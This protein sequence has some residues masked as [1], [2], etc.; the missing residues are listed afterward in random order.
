MLTEANSKLKAFC[1]K[2]QSQ[3]S[4]ITELKRSRDEMNEQFSQDKNELSSQLV[5]LRAELEE[6]KKETTTPSEDISSEQHAL[7][8]ERMEGLLSEKTARIST[9]EKEQCQ[10]NDECDGLKN[11]NVALTQQLSDS[12]TR[13]EE[14]ESRYQ[15]L[16]NDNQQ[17]K[18]QLSETMSKLES[19][20]TDKESKLIV[21]LEE[22]LA[23]VRGQLEE[24]KSDMMS[25][26]ETHRE[27]TKKLKAFILKLKKQLKEKVDSSSSEVA[28]R[29]EGEGLRVAMETVTAEKDQLAV[30]LSE[31]QT[32][33]QVMEGQVQELISS[34][35]SRDTRIEELVSIRDE[36]CVRVTT[37][38]EG[39]EVAA[40]E[41]ASTQADLAT[42]HSHSNT[43]Q[44]TIEKL[45]SSVASVRDELER[46][47]LSHSETRDKLSTAQ[48]GAQSSTLMNLELQDYQRSIRSLEEEV[49][50]KRAELES[51]QKEIHTHLDKIEQLKKELECTGA[52]RGAEVETV[53]KLKALLVR[54]KKE[55]VEGRRKEVELGEQ[56][57]QLT[58]QLESGRGQSE[59][60]KVELSELSARLHSEQLASQSSMEALQQ[61]V[62]GLE[63]KTAGLQSQLSSSQASLMLVQGEYDSYKVRVHSVLKQRSTAAEQVDINPEIKKSYEDEITNLK[64]SL[65]NTKSQLSVVL[66]DH[67]ELLSEHDTL[68]GR[69]DSLLQEAQTTRERLTLRVREVESAYNR[70]SVE[71][72]GLV[73]Q[74]RHEIEELTTAFTNQI[75]GL[76][77][78][79]KKVVL[80]LR[81]ELHSTHSQL[82][83]L[84]EEGD[85]K[86]FIRAS[87]QEARGVVKK[88]LSLEVKPGALPSESRTSGVG[89]DRS[90]LESSYPSTPL[91]REDSSASLERLL[92]DT[93]G[94]SLTERLSDTELAL[95]KRLQSSGVKIDH[96]TE[97]LRES[98]ASSV[99]LSEQAKL[100][101]EEIRRLERNQERE[102]VANMEYLKN[103]VLEFLH[104]QDM[105]EREGL[106][107][108][109]TKLLQLSPQEV[110]F[111]QDSIQGDVGDGLP[112]SAVGPPALGAAGSKLS[113]YIHRWTGY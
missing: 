49:A 104:T 53:S 91:S 39:R 55:L 8:V 20:Q 92:S 50:S 3:E 70:E 29:E 87:S 84:Q 27:E 30:R 1:E 11:R 83:R 41:L 36:L 113:S 12:N 69:H 89:M 7:Q 60:Y 31:A 32:N 59:E 58:A 105:K 4:A 97:L 80:G 45:Q 26:H 54:N 19:A 86:V 17:S 107:P 101:K 33:S 71:Q 18:Y 6:A 64:A 10:L 51:T 2:V 25:E 111:V 74:L 82:S 34:L 85:N 24:A 72:R 99:R 67:D 37:M 52:Q 22:Q 38:E 112:G 65:Q 46:E 79:H 5:Q 102:G 78:E 43:Q 61:T 100:L 23:E 47:Q 103:V 93:G 44:H 35:T 57:D 66:S 28:L 16:E 15:D 42:A 62:R 56:V 21:N 63:L 77:Q 40:S 73:E 48:K 9:L 108:V 94:G 76:Q 96:V 95:H 110:K 75:T 109:I 98:E 68:T 81:E 13:L 14:L 106:V 88:G 90:E